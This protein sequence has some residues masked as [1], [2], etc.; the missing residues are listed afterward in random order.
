MHVIEASTLSYV[1]TIAAQELDLLVLDVDGKVHNN[2]LILEIVQLHAK[3][4]A[5]PAIILTWDNQ[6]LEYDTC[7]TFNASFPSQIVSLTKPFDARILHRTVDQLLL[8]RA[9]SEAAA[10]ARAEAIL[11]AAYSTH[12]APS[13]WP[14]VTAAGILLAVVGMLVQVAVTVLGVL[15]VVVALLLWTLGPESCDL[16]LNEQ[17]AVNSPRLDVL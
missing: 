1:P 12:A 9:E 13:V 14:V 7:L 15:I 4:S 10:E 2:D 6:F 16:T 17:V 11:L 3:F 5:L 8:A